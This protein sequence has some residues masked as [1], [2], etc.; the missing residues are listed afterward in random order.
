MHDEHDSR[1]NL[2]DIISCDIIVK[3]CVSH[4]L[5]SKSQFISGKWK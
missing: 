2:L 1:I 3:D 5:C 4:G